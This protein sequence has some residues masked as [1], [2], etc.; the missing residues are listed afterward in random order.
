MIYIGQKKNKLSESDFKIST[1]NVRPA[2]PGGK[3]AR[4][5][6]RF[7]GLKPGKECQL[8]DK[9]LRRIL[10]AQR[11]EIEIA[12]ALAQPPAVGRDEQRHVIIC[13]RGQPE[14]PLEPQLPRRG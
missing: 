4:A 1:P 6:G 11:A 8:S 5:H 2:K 14:R 3:I 10:L 13:G 12:F 7:V 9:L